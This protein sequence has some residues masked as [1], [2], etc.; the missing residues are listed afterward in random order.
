MTKSNLSPW[1]VR[2]SRIV[3]HDRWIKLRADDCVTENGVE[4]APFYVLENAVTVNVV[5]LDTSDNVLLLRQYRHGAGT[6]SLELPCGRLE[7]HEH[8]PIAA[9]ARELLEE[10]GYAASRM[11][12]VA[13]LSPNAANHTGWAHIIL[14]ENVTQIQAPQPEP[15]EDLEIQITPYHEAV[16]LAMSG[17]I[18]QAMHVA[19]LL[20]A[21]RAAGKISL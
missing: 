14:A 11:S 10:T 3:H 9:A 17:A 13:R 8:D 18:I 15:S 19:G 20:I 7:P 2:A 6:I 5:A 4:I 12:P 1:K 16:Q 21:L